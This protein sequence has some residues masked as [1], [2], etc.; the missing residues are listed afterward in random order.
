MVQLVLQLLQ[1]EFGRLGVS[2]GLLGVYISIVKSGTL[3]ETQTNSNSPCAG[4]GGA[5]AASHNSCFGSSSPNSSLIVQ[6][7]QL[8]SAI[9]SAAWG[10]G[11]TSSVEGVC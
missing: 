2:L 3:N 8:C 9:T 10:L 4:T 11:F 1:W 5:C 7:Q 6:V